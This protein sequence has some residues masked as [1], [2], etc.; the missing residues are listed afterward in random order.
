LS[1]EPSGAAMK[2]RTDILSVERSLRKN[3][4][5]GREYDLPISKENSTGTS[6]TNNI[7]SLALLYG[8]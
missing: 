3:R 5:V 6:T 2:T 1:E 4:D 7:F 8:Y